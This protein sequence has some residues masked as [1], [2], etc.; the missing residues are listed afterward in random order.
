MPSVAEVAL[1]AVRLRVTQVLPMQVRSAVEGLDEQQIWWRPNEKANSIGNLVLHLAGSLDHYLNLGIGGFPY[2]RNRDAEFAARGTAS[3]KE[4]L[5]RFD[6]MVQRAVK[7]FAALTP[8]RLAGPTADP[9]RYT[10][11][12]EDLINIDTHMANHVGQVVWIAKALKEGSLDEVWI[13]AHKR[14]GAWK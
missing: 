2:S 11:L 12:I 8:E 1:E 7:T 4:L 9:E 6:E 14:G 5:A 10:F 3:K 13:R